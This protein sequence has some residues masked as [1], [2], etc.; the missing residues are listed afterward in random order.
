[1]WKLADATTLKAYEKE[2]VPFRKLHD[3]L[4]VAI[5]K[6]ENREVIFQIDKGI[7]EALHR[8]V[9]GYQFH[10]VERKSELK[11]IAMTL[12]NCSLSYATR[13]N[14]YNQLVVVTDEDGNIMALLEIQRQRIVQAKLFANKKVNTS[15]RINRACADYSRQTKLSCQTK[16][17]DMEAA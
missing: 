7:I 10:C 17:I 2:K 15:E 3:W 5:T 16:D 9:D 12:H 13:I 6:Q 11:K 4:S 1:M 8:S 14:Q